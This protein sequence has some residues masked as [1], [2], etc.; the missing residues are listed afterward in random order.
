MQTAIVYWVSMKRIQF[1][2]LEDLDWMP[3][4]IRDGGTDLLDLLFRL[5]GFYRPLVPHFATLLRSTG[6]Q[7]LNDCCS[8]GGGGALFM[9][10]ALT[11]SE[12]PNLRLQ[13]SD[14]HPNAGA[15][16]RVNALNNPLIHYADLGVDVMSKEAHSVGNFAETG[17][18]VRTMFSALHH[19]PPQEVRAILQAAVASGEPVAI[20]D[21]A[22]NEALRK[23]PLPIVC[24][25]LIPNAIVLALV[26]LIL[27]PFARPFRWSRLGWT[28]LFPAI[29]LLFVWDGTVSALRAYLGE[30]LLEA[31]RSVTGGDRYRWETHTQRGALCLLGTPIAQ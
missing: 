5:V 24:V 6:A 17:D 9:H 18:G 8:G 30:E 10:Q 14:L 12:L 29:P 28:Y 11:E 25:L 15:R 1:I 19:F 21:V 27:A 16:A 31:A 13:L 20:F 7:R 23:L 26:A 4:S 22:A 2:E 3:R